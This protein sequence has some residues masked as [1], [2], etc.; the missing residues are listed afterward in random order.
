[1]EPIIQV[2]EP[3]ERWLVEAHLVWGNLC[4]ECMD[5]NISGFIPALLPIALSPGASFTLALNSALSDGRKGLAV[6]L[7]GTALGI[8]THALLIGLG[9]TTLLVTSP[10]VF[11]I[12]KVA[13]IIYLLWLGC[14]LI[15]SGIKTRRLT[16]SENKNNISIKNAYFANIL[17]PKAIL[18]YLTVVSHFAGQ[19][20][21]V[22]HYLILATVHVIVMSLWLIIMSMIV[23]I[24]SRGINLTM[25]RRW[26][27]ILGGI[28]LIMLSLR[29]IL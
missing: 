18:F 24:S 25:L 9:I 29:N 5:I 7:A 12:L 10:S 23:V 16:L 27:N 3:A 19:F 28:L 4:G 1:M 17:N 6:T 14:Q 26:I 20:G 11:G 13:G 2:F 22:S 15:Y 8:Y 21:E